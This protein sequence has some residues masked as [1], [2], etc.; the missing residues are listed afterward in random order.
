MALQPDDR[1]LLQLVCERGQ[2]YDDIAG[3]LGM[4]R[5]QVHAKARAALAELGGADPDAEVGLTDYLLG[6]A[7][8]IGRADAVRYLQGNEEA[9]ALAERIEGELRVVA[10]AAR[11][12]RLPEPRGRRRRAA[13]PGRGEADIGAP[14][15][16]G[17]GAADAAAADDG[18]PASTRDPRQTRMIAAIAGLGLILLVVVLAIAGVFSGDDA[19]SEADPEAVAAEE[20][21]DIT[22]VTLDAVDGSGVAGRA[23]FGVAEDT[24][25]VDLSLNGLDPR[26]EEGSVYALW[27]MLTEEAGYPVTL[28]APSESGSV[29]DRFAI[30]TSVAA[31]VGSRARFV[32]VS[33]SPATKLGKVIDEAVES[34]APLVPFSGTPLAAGDIPLAEPAP[35][36]AEGTETTPETTTP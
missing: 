12:P 7:D 1:A 6:Q 8:P 25:Y 17:S 18:T 11:L 15:A 19:A 2:S 28:L 32:Q 29:Q 26:P 13:V 9:L 35:E 21:R 5:D 27:L 36:S 22:P 16:S 20:Q 24:L 3:L 10:P 33:E 14:A 30:P 4:S 34:G 23:E 31:V